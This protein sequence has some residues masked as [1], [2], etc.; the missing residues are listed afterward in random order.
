MKEHN[1]TFISDWGGGEC[2]RQSIILL[3]VSKFRLISVLIR[4]YK[5]GVT[6]TKHSG[7]TGVE[8][9]NLE[10]KLISWP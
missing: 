9:H 2:G 7:F 6:I 8:V 1:D 3:E 10:K 5:N 4:R